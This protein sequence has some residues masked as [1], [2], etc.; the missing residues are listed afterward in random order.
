MT[1]TNWRV[2]A[3]EHL[4]NQHDRY[5]ETVLASNPECSVQKACARH[6]ML[7]NMQSRLGIR[8]LAEYYHLLT[9]KPHLHKK[10]S[11]RRMLIVSKSVVVASQRISPPDAS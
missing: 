6:S 4:I 1:V 5:Q 10:P 11:D 3:T 7:S 8:M 9:L 2:E